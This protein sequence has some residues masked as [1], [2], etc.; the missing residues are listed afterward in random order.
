MKKLD[1]I[2]KMW[3]AIVIISASLVTFNAQAQTNSYNFC[4]SGFVSSPWTCIGQNPTPADMQDIGVVCAVAAHSSNPQII[5]AGGGRNV[6][7]LRIKSL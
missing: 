1:Q 5:Y 7:K 4:S 2:L 3:M 6:I